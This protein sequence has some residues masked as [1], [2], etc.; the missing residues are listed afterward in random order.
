MNE[1]LAV[2]TCST[3]YAL[4]RE[5]GIDDNL[6]VLND[7]VGDRDPGS[8]KITKESLRIFFNMGGSLLIAHTENERVHERKI[9]GVSVLA[10]R[11]K[12]NGFEF[13]TYPGGVVPGFNAD[14]VL[15]LLFAEK[16]KERERIR[17][18]FKTG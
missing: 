5:I 13:G 11:Y 16:A 3:L 14:E 17:S 4:E 6:Q 2:L 10:R 7:C 18:L 1:K 12:L 9:A 8:E 15:G